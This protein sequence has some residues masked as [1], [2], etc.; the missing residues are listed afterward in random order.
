MFSVGLCN[1]NTT[2][3]FPLFP[4]KFHNSSPRYRVS[5]RNEAIHCLILIISNRQYA[6][7]YGF[8]A[9]GAAAAGAAGVAGAA[10]GGGTNFALAS[11]LVK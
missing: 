6:L 9:A 1:S 3:S 5:Y 11:G 4:P 8:F 7:F 10:G 2:V